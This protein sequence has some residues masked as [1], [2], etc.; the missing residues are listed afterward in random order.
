MVTYSAVGT[1]AEVSEY[2]AAFADHADADELM[3][4]H[5]SPSA[6]T[7][8]RSIELLANSVPHS[9]AIAA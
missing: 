6:E 7:R 2:I 4:V 8:L 3:T 9:R 1:P 5:P